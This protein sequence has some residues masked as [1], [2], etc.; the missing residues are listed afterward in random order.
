MQQIEANAVFMQNLNEQ[1]AVFD[2]NLDVR[3][4]NHRQHTMLAFQNVL[5]QNA[6][7]PVNPHI[8][9]ILSPEQGNRSD[10]YDAL[11]DVNIDI[12]G[13]GHLDIT[14]QLLLVKFGFTA[15]DSVRLND[16]FNLLFLDCT[17]LVGFY[18]D[19][20]HTTS[21]P[22]DTFEH[23]LRHSGVVNEAVIRRLRIGFDRLLQ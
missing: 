17:T 3:L 9:L 13:Q 1:N 15:N 4:Q 21:H 18:V 16:Q 5:Q 14:M 10:V 23:R 20:W 19:H 7:A 8:N 2:A 12:A 11:R 22:P 6:Q